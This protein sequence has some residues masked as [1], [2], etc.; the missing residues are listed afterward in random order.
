[1]ATGLTAGMVFAPRLT[2]TAATMLTAVAA[3]DTLQLGYD[4]AKQALQKLAG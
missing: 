4:A 1:V 2:R 3:S